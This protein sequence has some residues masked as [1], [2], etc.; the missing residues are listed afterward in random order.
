MGKAEERIS[1]EIPSRRSDIDLDENRR[2]SM[3]FQGVTMRLSGMFAKT[4]DKA[5]GNMRCQQRLTVA[6][7]D[8][9]L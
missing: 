9:V 6:R 4:N 8:S 1:R 7:P 2:Q 3:D 5:D